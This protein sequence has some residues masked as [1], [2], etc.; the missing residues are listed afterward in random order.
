M[1]R[2]LLRQPEPIETRAIIYV[3]AILPIN[4]IMAQIMID[5]LKLFKLPE[6]V[7]QVLEAKQRIIKE[8]TT[9]TLKFRD[10]DVS[11][12]QKLKRVLALMSYNELTTASTFYDDMIEILSVWRHDN[13]GQFNQD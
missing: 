7:Q 11:T 1:K 9:M 2:R 4:A 13:P 10:I 8:T 5:L 12:R 3:W 6:M